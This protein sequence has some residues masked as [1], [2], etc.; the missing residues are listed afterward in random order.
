[1]E[2]LPAPGSMAA[3]ALGTVKTHH[4]AM[5]FPAEWTEAIAVTAAPQ[6]AHPAAPAATA[7]ANRPNPQEQAD[8]TRREL[9]V[10]DAVSIVTTQLTR[11]PANS[12]TTGAAPAVSTETAEPD[13]AASDIAA[14]SS[15]GATG[16]ASATAALSRAETQS[17]TA[18]DADPRARLPPQVEQTSDRIVDTIESDRAGDPQESGKPPAPSR[19]A[20]TSARR[21]VTARVQQSAATHVFVSY[22]AAATTVL[23]VSTAQPPQ[24]PLRLPS[25]AP[26]SPATA[27]ASAPR[28][29]SA[30]SAPVPSQAGL[31]GGATAQSSTAPRSR[32]P[33]AVT[34]ANAPDK[35]GQAIRAD[36]GDPGPTMTIAQP[37][38]APESSPRLPSIARP[39]PAANI[40]P[41]VGLAED[42]SASRAG[43]STAQATTDQSLAN[44][45]VAPAAP[46]ATTPR[47]RPW[48]RDRTHGGRDYHCGPQ[49]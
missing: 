27:A 29:G 39:S 46:P 14:S 16:R 23:V 36:V 28:G 32:T 45:A 34:G 48:R 15:R 25:S 20:G 6:P 41:K 13:A 33:D 17:K 26:A 22:P 35:K 49:P 21:A 7:R 8:G 3:P 2:P 43:I 38:V 5:T 30:G 47:R 12:A 9:S 44:G 18:T 31:T 37:S 4:V 19:P 10:A 1:M 24:T 42:D 40:E 11:A